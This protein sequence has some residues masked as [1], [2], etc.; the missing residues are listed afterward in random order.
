MSRK[1]YKV[2]AEI[3]KSVRD[4]FEYDPAFIDCTESIAMSF[5]RV[6]IRDNARFDMDKFL[7]ACGVVKY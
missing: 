3:I 2:I 5:V 7:K 4:Q 6:L 1:D